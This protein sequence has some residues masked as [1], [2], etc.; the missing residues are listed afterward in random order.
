MDSEDKEEPDASATPPPPESQSPEP[1]VD[2]EQ[3]DTYIESGTIN[4][5][6]KRND[7]LVCDFLPN[8]LMERSLD[9]FVS[10]Q[11]CLTL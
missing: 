10:F 9:H 8:G 5:T 1:V 11:I 2:L 6:K 7:S 3:M 4:D